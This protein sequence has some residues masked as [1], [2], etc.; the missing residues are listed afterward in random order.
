M[1]G[2]GQLGGIQL[3]DA[4]CYEQAIERMTRSTAIRSAR[5][6]HLRRTRRTY[7]NFG[8]TGITTIADYRRFDLHLP[9]IRLT[10]LK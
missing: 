5:R 6:S 2:R 1:F 8:V 3:R 4:G 10:D 7:H 9:Q